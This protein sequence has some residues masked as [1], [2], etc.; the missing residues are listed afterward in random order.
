V[1][2]TRAGLGIDTVPQL[3]DYARRN[4]GKLTCASAGPG[5]T[6]AIE[7]FKTA[8]GVNILSVPYKGFTPAVLDVASGQVD[9]VAADVAVIAP[10]VQSGRIRVIANAGEARSRAYPNLRTIAE[11]GLA[12]VV[13]DSWQS[14]VVPRGTPP[15]IVARLQNGLQAMV[16]STGFRDGLMRLGFETIE[17]HP[18]RF[19]AVLLEELARN[20][21]LARRAGVQVLR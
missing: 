8:A 20:R 16:A 15:E 9:L 5:A 10:F 18:D 13:S 2:A 6:M 4:P 1:L 19:P 17:E 21:V 11:E 14:I 12:D 7:A 3:I